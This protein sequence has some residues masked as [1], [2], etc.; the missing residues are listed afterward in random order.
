MCFGTPA[1]RFPDIP[2]SYNLNSF[3][4]NGCCYFIVIIFLSAQPFRHAAMDDEGLDGFGGSSGVGPD[5]AGSAA[6][7][8]SRASFSGAVHA[9]N[10]LCGISAATT[11]I[12]DAFLTTMALGLGRFRSF[13]RS[14]A[15][16]LRQRSQQGAPHGPH[17]PHNQNGQSG[18]NGQNNGQNGT[19]QGARA[20]TGMDM[21]ELAGAGVAEWFDFKVC[22]IVF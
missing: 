16:L 19:P 3:N 9:D 7:A 21:S 20:A 15:A 6:A 10:G 13:L 17:G 11:A 18:Q 12:R 2:A 14:P 22:E 4:P 1:S 5:A 8:R